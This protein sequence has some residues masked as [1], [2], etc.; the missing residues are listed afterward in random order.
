MVQSKSGTFLN[1]FSNNNLRKSVCTNTLTS[2]NNFNSNS[3][4]NINNQVMIN[5]IPCINCNN[6]ISIDDIGN[7]FSLKYTTKISS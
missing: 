3:N 2:S 1:T 4:Y 5:F 7:K 6:M